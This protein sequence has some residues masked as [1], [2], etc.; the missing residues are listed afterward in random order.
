MWSSSRRSAGGSPAGPPPARRRLSFQSPLLGAFLGALLVFAIAPHCIGW[1][2]VP[3]GGIGAVTLAKYRKG[4]D[5]FVVIALTIASALGALALSPRRT[6]PTPD[7]RPPTPSKRTATIITTIAVFVVMMVVHDHPYSFMEMFHEGEHLAPASVMLDGGRPYGDIFFLHGFATDGGLDTLVLGSK[8]SPKKTRRLETVLDAAAL[9]MLVPIAA[10][11][12]ASTGGLIAAVFLALCAIG[13]GE[14][15]VFPYFRWLPLLIA[16]WAL[17]VYC[18]S[19]ES[20]VEGRRRII[21]VGDTASSPTLLYVAAIASSLG[22]LW[23]LDVGICAVAASAIVILI[24]TRRVTFIA[25]AAIAAP[26]IVLVVARADL[27]H[28]FRDSFVIIPR[29][30]DAI[31]SLP[32]KPLPSLALLI[33]PVQLWEWLAS[34]AARYYLPPVF[35]GF[36]LALAV[37]KRDMRIAI[38]AIFSITLFR[39]AAGR[40]SWSHTRFG[41]PLLGIAVV[42]FLFEPLCRDWLR[43]QRSVWRGVAIVVFSILGFRYFEVALNATLGWKFIAGWRAR[44]R[45]EGMVPYPMPRGRGIFTYAENASDL[46][47]L[48]DLAQQAGPGTIFDLS[49]ERALYY[50]LDRRP[51]TRCPDIAML[52]TPE[53]SAEALHQLA[54]HPPVFVVLEGMKVFGSLDGIANRDRIPPIAAW[55]DA[56]YPVRVRAGRYLVGF[57][58]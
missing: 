8:P 25:L 48:R 5:Y 50:L 49:G 10:E 22:I 51:A 12:T 14:V 6:T 29:A 16:V 3:T 39:T 36:L 43:R 46:A 9:A 23:S 30:I 58:N 15:P 47:A 24:Y 34:E 32:A 28:F 17:L 33:H 20:G 2:S 38:V 26:L 44:Q 1:F 52:S 13:A 41:I 37:R 11:V 54:A 27:Y 31:W 19:R 55:I 53:L 4:F 40:C 18:R 45:H 42:A 56:T 21:A 7:T 35:F 57:R